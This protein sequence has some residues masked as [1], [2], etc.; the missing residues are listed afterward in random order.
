MKKRTLLLS[1]FLIAGLFTLLDGLVHY[2]Y[3]PLEIY[4]YP[5]HFL[6]IQ[7]PLVNYAL[8]KWVSSTVLL[9]VLFYLFAETRLGAR[10]Q[11]TV[12]A[13]IIVALL[14]IRYVLGG[15]YT[16]TWHV[17]NLVNH[18]LTLLLSIHLVGPLRLQRDRPVPHGGVPW[19]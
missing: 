1:S 2:F 4:D 15:H 12:I 17:L 16:P 18:T 8:S 7:S 13:L 6:G 10:S 14:E 19:K 3:E 9:F 11:Y 5:I